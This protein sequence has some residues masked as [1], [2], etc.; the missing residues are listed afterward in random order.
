MGN[1]STSRRGTY[2]VLALVLLGLAAALG[3]FAWW[4]YQ[5]R[6]IKQ[7]A[8]DPAGS[9]DWDRAAAQ[10]ETEEVGEVFTSISD[11][12]GARSAVLPMGRRLVER[13]PGF[14][15]AHLLYGQML[16]RY[17]DADAGYEQVKR[18]IEINPNQP[19]VQ[20]MAGTL[21][22]QLGA[23]EAALRHVDDALALDPDNTS[24]RVLKAHV[25]IEMGKL[26][27]AE[28]LLLE[29]LQADSSLHSAY[30][31]QASLYARR[32]NVA[33]AVQQMRKALNFTP[34]YDRQK[35]ISYTRMLAT[36]LRRQIKPEEAALL[37][38]QLPPA[39]RRKPEV[40][41]DLATSY[42]MMQRPELAAAA[43]EEALEFVPADDTLVARA[44]H[45]RLQAGALEQARKHVQRLAA[46]NPRNADLP[47]LKRELET[48]LAGDD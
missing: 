14:A 22:I 46:M 3:A 21:A 4:D 37:L 11:E 26:D 27:D 15:P 23:L 42:A 18:S 38:T 32:G 48:A 1:A 28:L 19:T 7:R 29:A 35:R 39:E 5:A 17:G 8:T 16:V 40:L 30:A 24:T 44:A 6:Q 20:V 34:E 41:G 25:L 43:Y 31:V 12:P 45:W 33:M 10:R 9:P 36:Y 13:Y 47:R 2:V